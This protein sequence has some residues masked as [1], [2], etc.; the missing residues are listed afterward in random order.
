MHTHEYTKGAT[1][2]THA[3]HEGDN[4]EVSLEGNAGFIAK[5]KADILREEVKKKYYFNTRSNV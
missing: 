2:R 3:Y 1:L 5:K 4:K